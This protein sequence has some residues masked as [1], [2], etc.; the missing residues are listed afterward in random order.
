VI[1][2]AIDVGKAVIFVAVPIDAVDVF[3]GDG[4]KQEDLDLAGSA[5]GE[6]QLS[7]CVPRERL[8][9]QE[10]KNSSSCW[11]AYN[12]VALAAKFAPG[13]VATGYMHWLAGGQ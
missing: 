3:V 1:E 6:S 12:S 8:V 13:L 7:V 9:A 11:Q 4:S 2:K 5:R 10:D